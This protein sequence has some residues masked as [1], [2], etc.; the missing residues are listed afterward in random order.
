LVVSFVV[1]FCAAF[2]IVIILFSANCRRELPGL[3]PQTFFLSFVGLC[4]S[5]YFSVYFCS[6]FNVVESSQ[7]VSSLSVFSI[8]WYHIVSYLAYHSL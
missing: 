8:V 1:I 3:T 6:L 4:F 2:V 5:F 7:L